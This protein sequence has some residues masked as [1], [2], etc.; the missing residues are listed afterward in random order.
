MTRNEALHQLLEEAHRGDFHFS[1]SAKLAIKIRN[2]LENPDC[3]LDE[4]G[5]LIQAEPLLASRV[6][7]LANSAI[8]NPAG[9][10]ITDVRTAVSRLGF[11]NIRLIAMGFV[12]RQMAASTPNPN[13]QKL[14]SSLWEHTAHVAALSFY[15]TAHV[16]QKSPDA[17]LFA[18]L[19]HEIGG[20][21]MLSRADELP[22]LL[23]WSSGDPEEIDLFS[24]TNTLSLAVLRNLQVPEGAI[25]PVEHYAE[26][27]LISPPGSIADALILADHL[28]PVPSP[29]MEKTSSDTS[30]IDQAVE[31]GNLL[32]ILEEA[33]EEVAALTKALS[34]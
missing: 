25:E 28:A 17:A 22:A 26:G 23:S 7:A 33:N 21:Y 3:H 10:E 8:Y 29:L 2:T 13:I 30:V 14:A 20:F 19:V 11:K 16:T 4:A 6:L 5:R 12:A 34:A 9:R 32:A 18:G 31:Q 27:F 24:V 1:T 15:I